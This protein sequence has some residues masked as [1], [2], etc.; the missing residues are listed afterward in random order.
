ML[1]EPTRGM[2][3]RAKEDVVGIVRSLAAEGMTVIVLSTEPEAVL[4][5]ADRAPTYDARRRRLSLLH[6]RIHRGRSVTRKICSANGSK[7]DRPN[8]ADFAAQVWWSI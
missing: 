8:T 2:D 1:V 6:E 4:A 5:V 7:R 3:V